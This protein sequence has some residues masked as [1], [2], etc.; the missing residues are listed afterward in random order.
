MNFWQNE[1]R[2]VIHCTKLF[3]FAILIV[4]GVYLFYRQTDLKFY[5]YVIAMKKRNFTLL[6][7][8]LLKKRR[9]GSLIR[10]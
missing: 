6:H 1:V 10:A 7:L 9:C 5:L 8:H 4:I 2:I 3:C